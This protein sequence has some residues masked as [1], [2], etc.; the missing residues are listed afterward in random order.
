M[1]TPRMTKEIATALKR[2]R[3]GLA[4]WNAQGRE[5]Q[6]AVLGYADGA[7]FIAADSKGGPYAWRVED[8]GPWNEM[9]VVAAPATEAQFE[10][11]VR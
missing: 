2:F 7:V 8:D 11:L 9:D 10:R 6:F 1:T 5:G 4:M 3:Q